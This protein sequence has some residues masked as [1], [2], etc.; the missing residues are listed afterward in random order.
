M[1][2]ALLFC[3]G[4]NVKYRAP[5]YDAGRIYHCPKCN[6]EVLEAFI[7][8]CDTGIELDRCPSCRGVWLDRN[9]LEQVSA[10][11]VRLRES[12]Q[13]RADLASK[14]RTALDPTPG[15]VV[16]LC[17]VLS[18]KVTPGFWGKHDD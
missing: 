15:W 11:M 3:A 17:K 4:C 18:M 6:G 13:R 5:K 1:A 2:E 9:E 7:Y 14:Q 16:W 8:A 10:L 12:R